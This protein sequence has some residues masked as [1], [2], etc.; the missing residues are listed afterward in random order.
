MFTQPKTEEP[1]Q[2]QFSMFPQDVRLKVR[3]VLCTLA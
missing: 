3:S 2:S 1:V